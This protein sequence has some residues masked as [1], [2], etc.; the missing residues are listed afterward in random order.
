MNEWVNEWVSEWVNEWLIEWVN[1]WDFW[2]I[3]NKK[4]E[5]T[6]KCNLFISNVGS[7][8]VNG[9]SSNFNGTFPSFIAISNWWR[10]IL[11]TERLKN[12]VSKHYWLWI[13]T[14]SILTPTIDFSYL[15]SAFLT[16]PNK[17]RK[18]NFH[19]YSAQS[20]N[21]PLQYILLWKKDILAH[22]LVYF[23]SVPL[24]SSGLWPMIHFTRPWAQFF[25]ANWIREICKI[26]WP[27]IS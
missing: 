1:E 5:N 23:T 20:K 8:A 26:N 19:P 17:L 6:S 16:V 2:T 24:F 11:R 25:I 13:N 12:D 14:N 10:C 18:F 27:T 4:I 3:K 7:S 21:Q 15:Y 9:T 22:M